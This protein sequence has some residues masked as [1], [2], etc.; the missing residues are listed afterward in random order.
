VTIH[1]FVV[2]VVVGFQQEEAV[3]RNSSEHFSFENMKFDSLEPEM[4][5]FKHMTTQ[6]LSK[7][8]QVDCDNMH[9]YHF[10]YSIYL[11]NIFQVL[12]KGILNHV[13]LLV[14]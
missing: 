12:Q 8:I 5:V 4:T 6:T 7:E 1:F 2:V 9:T 11:I 14:T 13:F 3:K 10:R